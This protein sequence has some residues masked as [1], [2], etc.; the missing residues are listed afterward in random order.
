MSLDTMEQGPDIWPV[1]PPHHAAGYET[2]TACGAGI[3]RAI[4]SAAYWAGRGTG[5]VTAQRYIEW[6][7][8]YM[9]GE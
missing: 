7:R 3:D 6:R 5:L 2:C 8:R 1:G 9:E 4:H